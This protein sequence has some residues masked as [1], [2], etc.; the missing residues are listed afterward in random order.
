[1]KIIYI[2]TSVIPAE[3]AN[4]Y[5][6]MKMCEAFTKL[7]G[8][9]ELI[10]PVRFGGVV[11]KANPFEYYGIREKFKIK[12]VFSLDLIPFK[13]YIG[14]LGFWVQN[15]SFALLTLIYLFFKR[16]DI[17][18]SRDRFTLLFLSLFKKNLIYEAHSLPSKFRFYEKFLYQRIK[19]VIV[20]TKLMREILMKESIKEKNRIFVA[21]DAVDLE[22]FDR[23]NKSKEELRQE[24]N[25]PQHKIL[26]SYIGQF[27][28][29]GREKGLGDMLRALKILKDEGRGDLM[30]M[31]VGGKEEE[32]RDYQ[33]ETKR[34]G[35][36]NRD[37]I[38]VKRVP[39]SEVPR[40]EKASDI[41]V[42][43]FPW[44][45][46]YAYYCSPLKLFEYMASRKPIVASDLPSIREILNERNSILVK[47]GDPSSLAKGIEEFLNKPDLAKRV[48][49]QASKD[50]QKYT[51]GRR[52]KKI[53]EFIHKSIH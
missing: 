25:L 1:M 45:K 50:V 53:L 13:K 32:I 22:M 41:L 12:R 51:W 15:I 29:K 18:Y 14:H 46:H 30:M 24:L 37:L 39:F 5:Q 10:I 44:E 26:I 28:T 36:L 33:E 20:I 47:P 40:Y 11:E 8:E 38:F 52:A 2:T 6:T 31:F 49:E 7:G 21:P 43:P 17:I 4:S 19:F 34:V 42:I 9:V 48:S 27:Y 16:S 35:L 3:K 23:I